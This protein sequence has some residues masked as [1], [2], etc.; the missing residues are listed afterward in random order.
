MQEIIKKKCGSSL[1]TEGFHEVWSK[2]TSSLIKEPKPMIFKD[3]LK[4]NSALPDKNLVADGEFRFSNLFIVFDNVF[5]H[6]LYKQ[7]VC[8]SGS[9]HV[10]DWIFHKES[11]HFLMSSIQTLLA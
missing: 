1:E 5:Q 2:Y 8:I 7:D 3:P 9:F 6:T 4:F 11:K 10:P